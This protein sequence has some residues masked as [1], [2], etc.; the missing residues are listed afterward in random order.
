MAVQKILT[1]QEFEKSPYKSLMSYEDYFK[2]ALKLGS[3]FTFAHAMTIKNAE[4]FSKKI[5]GDIEGYYIKKEQEKDKAEE[6]YYLALQQYEQMKAAQ[7]KAFSRLEY[8]TNVFGQDSS[9]FSDALKKYNL[10]DKSLFDTGVSL[11]IARDRFNSANINAFKTYL[12]T[13]T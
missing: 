3:A 4:D 13:L 6:E 5:K 7:K 9:Y 11:D 10:A 1:Q 12:S 2:S 8:T